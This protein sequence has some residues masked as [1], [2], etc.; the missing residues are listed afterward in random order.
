MNYHKTQVLETL[1]FEKHCANP[2]NDLVDP[3]QTKNGQNAP[4]CTVTS[5]I[6][7]LGHLMMI[8]IEMG[9]QSVIRAQYPLIWTGNV[10]IATRSWNQKPKWKPMLDSAI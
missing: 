10:I 1:S 6:L 7:G 9:H 5:F 2:K 8:T 4:S 3:H